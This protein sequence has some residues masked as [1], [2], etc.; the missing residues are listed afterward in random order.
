MGGD[1]IKDACCLGPC[2]LPTPPRMVYEGKNHVVC[3]SSSSLSPLFIPSSF[4]L[5][6]CCFI[7]RSWLV[8]VISFRL[9]CS[10]RDVAS[11]SFH[12]DR[13]PHGFMRRGATLLHL[14][15]GFQEFPD[16]RSI[17][18]LLQ[19][20]QCVQIMHTGLGARLTEVF[21]GHCKFR[22]SFEFGKSL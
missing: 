9:C 1:R 15:I 16:I 7:F 8:L 12:L 20:W 21:G 17:F 3:L 22:D 19:R 5:I 2:S 10:R 11:L 14:V 13:S 4:L 6:S 18:F